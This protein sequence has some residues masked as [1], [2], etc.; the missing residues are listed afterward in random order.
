MSQIGVSFTPSGGSPVYSFVFDNFGDNSLPRSYQ[1]E[2]AFSQSANG[3]TILDGPAYRQ[4]YIWVF[5]SIIPTSEAVQ[6]DA[7]FRA[8]DADRSAGL[9]VACGVTDET[10]GST[11]TTSAVFS[12][13]PTFVRMGPKLT[14]VAFGLTE[15]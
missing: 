11:V 4:K 6:V 2:A 3:T 7:M 10:F 12:T 15:V 8:W 14:M 9:P 5:S 1:V 13:P